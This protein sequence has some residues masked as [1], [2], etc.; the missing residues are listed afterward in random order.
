MEVFMRPGFNGQSS[1]YMTS[2]S[3]VFTFTSTGNP[4][5]FLQRRDGSLL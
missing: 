4:E 3:V 1:H 5:P 2:N